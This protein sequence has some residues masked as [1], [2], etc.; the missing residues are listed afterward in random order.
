MLKHTEP[1]LL[2][3]AADNN[4][5]G[6]VTLKP[7]RPR[8]PINRIVLH[9]SEVLAEIFKREPVIHN[10]IIHVGRDRQTRNLG[11]RELLDSFATAAY[12]LFPQLLRLS[13]WHLILQADL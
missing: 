4:V 13:F 1:N 11:D 7:V 8:N 3:T 5:K 10:Q 12:N 9:K 6:I 2:Q